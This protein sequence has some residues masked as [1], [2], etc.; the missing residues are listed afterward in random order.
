MV[1][2][3]VFHPDFIQEF[4]GVLRIVVKNGELFDFRLGSGIQNDRD[5]GMAPSDPAAYSSSV[6]WPSAIKR[7]T[8]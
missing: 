7:S 5:G 3:S 2:G 6:N 4:V 1:L 8:P